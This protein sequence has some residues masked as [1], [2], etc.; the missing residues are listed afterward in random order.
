MKRRAK[1]KI[2]AASIPFD[3]IAEFEDEKE[4][5]QFAIQSQTN[6]QH[7]YY[8]D[9]EAYTCDCGSYPLI[10]YWKHLAAVQLQFYEDLETPQMDSLFTQTADIPTSQSRSAGVS[11]SHIALVTPPNPDLAVLGSIPEK[12]QRLV[13][14][15]QLVPPHHLSDLLRQLDKL[16]DQVLGKCTWPQVLPKH[17]RVPSNQHSSWPQTAKVMGVAVKL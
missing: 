11:N 12:L 6:P 9:I 17:K 1:I 4:S 2:A 15:T 5:T 14:R 13:V 16:L 8:I 10:S 7:V 3:S